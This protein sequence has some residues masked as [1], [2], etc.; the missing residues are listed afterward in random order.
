[1]ALIVSLYRYRA[2]DK[3]LDIAPIFNLQNEHYRAK[4]HPKI[5]RIDY[6]EMERK[7]LEGYRRA[8]MQKKERREALIS[9][10]NKKYKGEAGVKAGQYEELEAKYEAEPFSQDTIQ[11]ERKMQ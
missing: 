4:F 2:E 8:K 5:Q 1:M 9:Q 6:E 10:F 11:K 3:D 7:E